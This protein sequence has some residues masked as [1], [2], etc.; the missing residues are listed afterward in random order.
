MGTLN[1]TTLDWAEQ[2]YL[3]QITRSLLHQR[4]RHIG[5]DHL[6]T[7]LKKGLADGITINMKSK[8]RDICDHCIAG[9]QHCDPF[10]HASEHQST[11]L[12]G[13]IHS[14]LHGP[15][16]KTPYGYRYWMTLVNDMS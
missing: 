11:T 13:R 14:D 3:M 15:L 4:L 16:P 2:V 9:K 1:G 12:L 10:L 6:E 8:L 5:K 7:L